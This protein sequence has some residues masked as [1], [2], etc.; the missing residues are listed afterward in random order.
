LGES[1]CFKLIHDDK[2][3]TLMHKWRFPSLSIHGVQG[4]F[5]GAGA[6]TVIPRKVIG[7]FSIRIVPDQDPVE[8]ERLVV[9]H[10]NQ[11]FKERNSPN[12]IAYTSNQETEYLSN[13]GSFFFFEYFKCFDGSR[14]QGLDG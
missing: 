8:I 9:N 6:K 7:K 2:V 4:A 14:S 10:L 12:K 5:D 11:K 3:N 1:G 13:C